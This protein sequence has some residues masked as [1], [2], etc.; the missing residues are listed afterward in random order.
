MSPRQSILTHVRLSSLMMGIGCVFAGTACA[1]IGG[2]TELLPANLCM[3]FV[4]FAQLAGNFYFRYFDEVHACGNHIDSRINSHSKSYSKTFLKEGSI[5]CALIAALAGLSIAVSGGWWT[6][7]VG[8]FV[9]FA[10]WITMG[11][12]MPLLR[13]PYGVIAPFILFGPVCVIT[14][15]LIQIERHPEHPL[16]WIDVAPA[17]Y[18]SIVMG[19]MCVNATMVYGY[20]NYYR[21][22]R[23]SKETLVVAV[24][25]K[26]ARVI[27]LLNG[28]IYTAVTIVMC[29]QLNFS[30]KGLDIVPSILCL[31]I[32]IY[33]LYQ[34]RTLPR[35]HHH[36]LIDF[37][38]FN[39][40]LMGLL[41]FIIF[42][43]TGTPDVSTMSF[44]GL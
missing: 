43:I 3:I 25:K 30:L 38:N 15:A 16:S 41:T 31:L 19:L 9:A 8:I 37:A 17:L 33:I 32:D 39:V 40:L 1:A 22:K 26:F 4:I 21:D 23:N 28:V 2:Y 42:E 35:E 24:G 13:T 12:N 36:T 11:G 29:Q 20:N 10:G 34:M 27:F 7:M 44:F 6:L 5:A 14:T 18:M